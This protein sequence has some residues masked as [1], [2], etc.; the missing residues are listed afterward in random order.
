MSARATRDAELVPQ[1]RTLWGPTPIWGRRWTPEN[2]TTLFVERC[3]RYAKRARRHIRRLLWGPDLPA[4][5]RTFRHPRRHHQVSD[6]Q[7]DVEAPHTTRRCR[8]R[9]SWYSSPPIRPMT[10]QRLLST[11]FARATSSSSPR[12][13][14]P[15]HRP[16]FVSRRPRQLLS[17]ARR[18]GGTLNGSSVGALDREVEARSDDDRRCAGAD[19]SMDPQSPLA[20]DDRLAVSRYGARPDWPAKFSSHPDADGQLCYWTSSLALLGSSIYCTGSS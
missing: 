8:L 12:V 7:D 10:G 16:Q 3:Q 15:R 13:D 18:P 20:I 1:L 4:G 14:P 6:P 9:T 19:Q 11:R 2:A 17:A 5:R